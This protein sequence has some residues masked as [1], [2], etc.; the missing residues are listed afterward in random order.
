MCLHAAE[1]LIADLKWDKSDIECLILV[2]QT[3]DYILPATACILQNRL[4]LPEE[5]YALD[6]SLG[7]SGWVYGM[8]VISSLISSGNMK[9]G[10]LLA[11]E[12]AHLHSNPLDKSTYPLFGD[13]GTATAIE[14]KDGAAGLQFHMAT[15]GSGYDAIIIEDGGYRNVVNNKSLELYTTPEGLRRTRLNTV[16]DGMDVFSFGI[17]KAPESF[18]KLAERFQIDRE[19]IDYY[20]MHQANYFMNNKIRKKLKIP[21]EKVPYSMRNFG[22]TSSASIPLTIVTECSTTLRNRGG[23]I[24]ASGFGVGLSWA[25]TY[26][27]L[28][29]DVVISDLVEI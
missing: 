23:T 7:C 26:F 3:P 9:K 22:N 17:S 11:G 12:I 21:E 29:E 1:K 5:C 2:T 6:I 20:I 8:S 19:S 27:K 25:T 13:A 4:G 14:F 15:D 28:E 18:N 10:L 24:I 16:M